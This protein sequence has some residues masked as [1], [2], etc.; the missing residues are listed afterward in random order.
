MKETNQDKEIKQSDSK[1][2]NKNPKKD[3]NFKKNK[4]DKLA[5]ADS[6]ELGITVKKDED[7]SEWYQQVILKSEL[8]EY[9]NVSGC[10]VFRP[11]SY[12]VWEAIQKYFDKKIKDDGVENAYFPLFIPESLLCKE[13]EHVKGFTPEVAWV[14]HGGDTKLTERL[15]IRPTSETIMYDSFK[16]WIRSYKDLPLRINQWCNVVRWEFKHAVPFIRTR[17][18]LWQE[19]HTVFAT[20]AE[21]ESEVYKILDMYEDVCETVLALPIL[22]GL[23]TSREK[24][25]G[26]LFTTS[27]E[28]VLPN[29]KVAQAGTSHCL[30]QNF[31]KAFDIKFLDHKGDTVYGWQ[32]SWGI[33][34]RL[35][36]VMIMMHSDDKGLV[37]PPKVAPVH[38]VIVPILFENTKQMV[39]EKAKELA[40]SFKK[41]GY[42]KI[43]LDDRE[44]YTAG[45]KY[46]EWEMKGVPVRIEIGPKDIEKNQC[47]MVRRDTGKKEFVKLAELNEKLQESLDNMQ[48]HLLEKARKV[49]KESIVK[50]KS[51]QDFI[52]AIDEK[53]IV[54][55]FF[56]D[57]DE[58]EETIKAKTGAK[59]VNIP[60]EQPEDIMNKKCIHCG[61]DAKMLLYFGK[62][63]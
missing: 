8:V 15:A 38:A 32:N 41:A 49:L 57:E 27:I 44:N 16:K 33:S 13:Q 58:C 12:A 24:F 20:Q 5:D 10:I 46:N 30:G 56:C 29:G 36:G 51:M 21:A 14:T 52:K 55:I 1:H 47:V 26:A 35:I 40:D 45:W 43:H 63:Y 59:S 7:F 54:E 3:D 61:K 28:A 17:E 37:L 34:T 25:A 4:S 19:G 18:F 2:D 60:K 9:T 22:K 62:S 48:H 42:F 39:I 50:P 31:A 23:K 6:K 11:R 53:K